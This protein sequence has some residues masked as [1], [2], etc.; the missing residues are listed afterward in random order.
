VVLAVDGDK[1][2]VPDPQHVHAWQCHDQVCLSYPSTSPL[3]LSL[4]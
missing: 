1:H 3:S 4:T 2:N